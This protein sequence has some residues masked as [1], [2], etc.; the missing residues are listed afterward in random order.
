MYLLS[1]GVKGLTSIALLLTNV[2]LVRRRKI[3]SCPNFWSTQRSSDTVPKQEQSTSCWK[4]NCPILPA[5]RQSDNFPSQEGATRFFARNDGFTCPRRGGRTF[6]YHQEGATR[7][8]PKK[9]V[10]AWPKKRERIFH[11]FQL[12]LKPGSHESKRKQPVHT[13][14]FVT[15]A[16]DI[17]NFS[18]PCACFT[19]VNRAVCRRLLWLSRD[20]TV[21]KRP[22]KVAS[23][24]AH[25][26]L[27][28]SLCVDSCCRARHEFAYRR[29]MHAVT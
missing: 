22:N 19:R 16:Q 5:R 7:I 4:K 21:E 18:I 24:T 14:K 10:F 12:K 15:Q 20:S 25:V 28:V 1:S 2:V 13:V 27:R 6:F 29:S 17:G 9:D 26:C 3:A 8:L 23:I 11:W